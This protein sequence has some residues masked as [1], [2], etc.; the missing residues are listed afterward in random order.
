MDAIG[1]VVRRTS[2]PIRIWND[3]LNRSTDAKRWIVV[4]ASPTPVSMGDCGIGGNVV[5]TKN[6]RV[7]NTFM[8]VL[9]ICFRLL[10]LFGRA[11]FLIRSC[12]TNMQ[13][14]NL[15]NIHM[16]CLSKM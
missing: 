14:H 2:D 6:Q 4:V 1:T 3:T 5:K 12:I 8:F 13:V 11:S 15:L 16:L 9:I 7:S 10:F